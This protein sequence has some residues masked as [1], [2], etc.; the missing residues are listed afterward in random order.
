MTDRNESY[1]NPSANHLMQRVWD[2]EHPQKGSMM[3]GNPRI[4]VHTSPV[5][6]VCK[7]LRAVTEERDAL[8]ARIEGAPVLSV[9]E[10]AHLVAGERIT[11]IHDAQ[12]FPYLAGKRVALVPLGD[13]EWLTKNISWGKQ[14][15]K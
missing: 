14:Y 7:A 6:H 11:G 12:A 10:H 2:A 1:G 9:I 15:G 8:R 5:S 3:T 4:T 13:D